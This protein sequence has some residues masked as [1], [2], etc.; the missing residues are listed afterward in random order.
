[1]SSY[2]RDLPSNAVKVVAL[3]P[4]NVTA[5]TVS[6]GIGDMTNG[7]G[8]CVLYAQ[9]GVCNTTTNLSIQVTESTDNSTW[10]NISG[11]ILNFTCTT[12]FA[13]SSQW[14]AFDRT[15]RYLNTVVTATGSALGANLSVSIYEQLKQV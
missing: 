1:M 12:P 8:R 13:N 9:V 4:I 15:A 11:A 14:V 10:T 7:D 2:L 5:N 3:G 6:S